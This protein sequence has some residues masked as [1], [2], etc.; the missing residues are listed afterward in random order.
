MRNTWARWGIGL[1][2]GALIGF[3]F[4][5]VGVSGIASAGNHASDVHFEADNATVY[6]NQTDLRVNGMIQNDGDAAATNLEI[7]LTALPEGWYS[8]K[9]SID[10]LDGGEEANFT[11]Y[12]DISD[13]DEN[14]ERDEEIHVTAIDPAGEVANSS[15]AVS[16]VHPPQ[17]GESTEDVPESDGVAGDD[18]DE[19]SSYEQCLERAD[20]QRWPTEWSCSLK[21]DSFLTGFWDALPEAP[22]WIPLFGE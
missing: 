9:E 13:A 14:A 20:D 18:V 19:E 5:G 11:L 21:Y 16:L 6:T 12:L 2:T 15:L 7:Q 3:L 1:I 8:S 4:V 10:H 17:P 22:D